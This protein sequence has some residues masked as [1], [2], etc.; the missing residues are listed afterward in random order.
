MNNKIFYLFLL[1]FSLS[2]QDNFSGINRNKWLYNSSDKVYYQLGIQYCENPADFT[3]QTLSLFVPEKYMICSKDG[4]FYSC[5]VSKDIIDN[6]YNSKNA[7]VVF[8]INTPGYA[9]AKAPSSYPRDVS[10]FTNSG[11]IYFYPGCR[12]RNHG[13]PSGVV[14]LKAAISF[15]KNQILLDLVPGDIQRFFSF[16]MSGGGAQSALIG[17]T[18]DS[19]LFDDYLKTIGAVTNTSN[20]VYGSMCWCPITNLDHADE[21]YEWSMGQSRSNLN[22]DEQNYS[23]RLAKSYCGYINKVGF[24]DEDGAILELESSN[25]DILGFYQQ[26]S[27]YDYI[28]KTIEKSF[29][30]FV[31]SNPFPYTPSNGRPFLSFASSTTY[32]DLDSYLEFLND[33][34]DEPWITYSDENGAK[35]SD[36]ANFSKVCK[37]SNKGIGAFDSVSKNT[38]ENL[39]F[40]IGND[41]PLHFDSVLGKITDLSEFENDL[42]VEDNLG[43]DVSKRLLMYTP[44]NYLLPKYEQ[45]RK[46]EVAKY[47]RIRTG[48]FQQDTSLCTEVNLYL[49]LKNYVG[50]ED[51]DFQTIWGQK[52]VEA[53]MSGSSNENFVEWV[54]SLTLS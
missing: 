33:K 16:G 48:L 7:P 11:L 4:N 26:G 24:K 15:I 50:V 51:V 18:G 54:K 9:A 35:I 28:K 40:G 23:D 43:N 30:Q 46:S 1:S 17:S 44:L 41:N 31:K 12:G 32:K 27:Y 34:Y 49:A 37:S 5:Q 47:W 3:Y 36:L 20:S 38:P 29:E 8:R 6:S 13:A 53:E 14:D 21:A 25:N 39:L 2:I 42:N 10:T 52:H 45:Y 19:P 22:I